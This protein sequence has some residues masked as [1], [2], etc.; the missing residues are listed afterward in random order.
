MP[1]L[2]PLL[3]VEKKTESFWGSIHDDQMH[4]SPPM[5][6]KQCMCTP[7]LNMYDHFPYVIVYTYNFEEEKVLHLK[8]FQV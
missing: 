5:G 3:R 2:D 6:E 1:F 8:L 7:K 4:G